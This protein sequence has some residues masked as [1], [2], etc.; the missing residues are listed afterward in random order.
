[1]NPADKNKFA[2][3]VPWKYRYYSVKPAAKIDKLELG[4]V[5]TEQHSQPN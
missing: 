5:V 3:E 2:L 1:M 4:L